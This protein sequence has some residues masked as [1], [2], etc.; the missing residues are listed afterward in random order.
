MPDSSTDSLFG[1]DLPAPTASGLVAAVAVEQ[2]V[3]R[4]LDYLVPRHLAQSVAVGQRVKVPLG[5]GNRQAYGYVSELRD[6]SE[7]KKL[8]AIEVIDDSRSLIN[9]EIFALARWMARYYCTPL[10]T[11]L[12]SVIPSA[13]KKRIGV[14]TRTIVYPGEKA[15][16][17]AALAAAKN[18]KRK[19]LLQM[20]LDLPEGGSV[21]LEEL[22]RD[23]GTTPATLRKLAQ[24][25]I[26]S[27][28]REHNFGFEVPVSAA[29]QAYTAPTLTVEQAAAL[30]E[31][32]ARIDESRFSVTLLHGVTGSGKTELYL[33]SIARVVEQGRQAIV[34]VPEIS[35]TPQTARRFIERFPQVS[36]LHSGLSQTDRHWHW[37]RIAAG[38]AQVVVGA[39]SAIF[40]P[41]PKPGIIIIDEE[42]E[43]S[44][45]QDTAPR[46]HARDIAIKRAHTL[47]IPVVLGSAT[48]SLEMYFRATASGGEARHKGTEARGDR[49]TGQAADTAPRQTADDP[50]THHSPLTTHSYHYLSLPHRVTSHPLP[51]V[52]IV[53]LREANRGRPGIHLFSPRLEAAIKRTLGAGQQV[54]LLLNRRGYA[55]YVCCSS[56]KEA[57]QCKYCDVAMT[58]H[59]HEG[60]HGSP[61]AADSI[62]LGKLQCHYCL[63]TNELP[64]TCPVCGKKLT[65]FGLGTQRV[66]EELERKFPGVRYARMDSDT[67]RVSG[68][69][70]RVLGQ[71]ATGDIQILAG[72]QMIAKGLDFPNVTL[73]GVIS[74]DTSLMLPDFRAAEKTFQLITQ[75]AGRA[76]RGEKPGTVVVQTFMPQDPTIQAAVQHDYTSFARREMGMRRQ[77]G[78][79]PFGRLARLVFRDIDAGKLE[80][81]A[82]KIAGELQAAAKAIPD[83]TVTGPLPC[84]I[85]RIAGQFR[86]EIVLRAPSAQSLQKLLTAL[87]TS[88]NIMHAA[89]IAI[90]VDPIS[91]L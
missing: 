58:Y 15:A 76:G 26:L 90:D 27:L 46:Y 9:P 59:R 4:E 10:G 69:Y 79:P 32:L 36:V 80:E 8:K 21:P 12:E 57:I 24:T 66:E 2:A 29:A 51:K 11:V 87:R 47:G 55:S 3:D 16:L 65:L 6:H 18:A 1:S 7:Y 72:T 20:L 49:K 42:H 78:Y 33:R 35:L 73:V 56:C 17:A 22:A 62:P 91:L 84:P 81:L 53:D 44:Y 37:R 39:R 45:K 31:L 88:G 28:S 52:E 75:V 30:Q 5:R 50:S 60:M 89:H 14:R 77:T 82:Q 40:A 48:P 68:D 61:R 25:P 41:L 13:V 43:S 71:F 64:A 70:E 63:A 67:M 38:E 23:V 34:L 85:G 83:I 86:S 19:R 74:G 54:I